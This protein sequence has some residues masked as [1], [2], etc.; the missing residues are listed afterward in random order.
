MAPE[1]AMRVVPSP[2]WIARAKAQQAAGEEVT[3]PKDDEQDAVA[4][5]RVQ[6]VIPSELVDPQNYPM[7]S[8]DL[9]ELGRVNLADLKARVHA[10]LVR[11][12][13]EATAAKV[14]PQRASEQ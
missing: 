2:E 1:L 13:D 9:V 4:V 12:G 3:P 10:T 11:A 14:V 5:L 8:T 7:V 6:Y